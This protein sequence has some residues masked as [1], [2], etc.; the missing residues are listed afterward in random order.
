M[1]RSNRGVNVDC[2]LMSEYVDEGEVPANLDCHPGEPVRTRLIA[3]YL[4][5]GSQGDDMTDFTVMM[6]GNQVIS[7]RGNALKVINPGEA[8]GAA[9]YAILR[10]LAAEEIVVALFPVS[11]VHGIFSGS[12]QVSNQSL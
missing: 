1:Q 5:A 3:D 2:R 12:I 6:T 10:R 8:G 7:V 4:D 9:H 11:S